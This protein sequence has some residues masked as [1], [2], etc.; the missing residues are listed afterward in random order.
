[1][2][3]LAVGIPAFTRVGK[4]G[5]ACIIATIASAP[6]FSQ[7][8]AN[9]LSFE[10]ASVKI[11]T[12]ASPPT[13]GCFPLWMGCRRGSQWVAPNA[14][15]QGLLQEAY[16]I[17]DKQLIGLPGW[18]QA[19][20]FDIEAKVGPEVTDAQFR[21]MQQALLADRFHLVA[22]RATRDLPAYTLRAATG[23]LK[24]QPSQGPCTV[25]GSAD[26]Q[27]PPCGRMGLI[28]ERTKAGELTGSAGLIHHN[29]SMKDLVS[30]LSIFNSEGLPMV[31]DTGSTAI[32]DLNLTFY[33]DP[34]TPK[35]DFNSELLRQLQKAF[36]DQVGLDVDMI[37]PTKRP[38]PILVVDSVSMPSAN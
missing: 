28:L 38:V 34:A 19:A 10:V 21:L 31:D 33:V 25:A 6:A 2:V 9:Q 3:K 29:I 14:F 18:A 22:H 30:Y 23:G 7:S 1:M 13:G 16:Q 4:F 15:L 5:A 26:S 11:S 17:N 27:P 32:F 12:P 37:R 8:A 20:R 24:F 36:H 35:D